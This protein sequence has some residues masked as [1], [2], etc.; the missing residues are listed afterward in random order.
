MPGG[1]PRK[2][3]E[4]LSRP[5]DARRHGQETVLPGGPMPAPPLPGRTKFS[6]ATRDWYD[7]WCRSPQAAQFTAPAWRRLFM[8]AW[9]VEEFNTT[10]DRQVLAEIRANEREFGATPEAMLRL[11]WTFA[12]GEEARAEPAQRRATRPDP[13]LRLVAAANPDGNSSS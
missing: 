8:L 13:R 5:R 11:H 7:D 9:L 10:H 2:P 12:S 4:Q 6:K 1:R 3:P